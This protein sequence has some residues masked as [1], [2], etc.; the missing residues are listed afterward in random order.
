MTT[1]KTIAKTTAIKYGKRSLFI[2]KVTI[3]RKIMA[4]SNESSIGKIIS[5]PKYKITNSPIK[6]RSMAAS[7]IKK[8]YFAVS[9]IIFCFKVD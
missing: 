5:S 7:L 9:D 6:H 3:G 2:K 1:K 4:N 8:G